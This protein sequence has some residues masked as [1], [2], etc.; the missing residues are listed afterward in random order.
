[1][2][3]RADPRFRRLLESEIPTFEVKR[4]PECASSL[5]EST[6]DQG[7]KGRAERRDGFLDEP[8]DQAVVVLRSR[9]AEQL[10][11]FQIGAR[12]LALKMLGTVS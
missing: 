7:L 12:K 3:V 10:A 5:A 11:N 8:H 1:M 9:L 2:V 4:L 6:V